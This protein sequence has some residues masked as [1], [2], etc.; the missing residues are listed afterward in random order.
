MAPEPFAT[1]PLMADEFDMIPQLAVSVGFPLTHSAGLAVLSRANTHGL[2]PYSMPATA[3]ARTVPKFL[4]NILMKL[5]GT[6]FSTITSTKLLL[7]AEGPLCGG[8]FT[9]IV[10]FESI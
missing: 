10:A 5:V 3:R 7:P 8:L 4:P 2:P 1:M 6:C 9:M